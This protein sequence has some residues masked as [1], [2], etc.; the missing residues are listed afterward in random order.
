MWQSQIDGI[1]NF[2]KVDDTSYTLFDSFRSALQQAANH[3]LLRHGLS[4][5]EAEAAVRLMLEDP[6]Y[7]PSA[8]R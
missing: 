6:K 7:F 8:I 2:Q 5:E 4:G 3:P 1:A